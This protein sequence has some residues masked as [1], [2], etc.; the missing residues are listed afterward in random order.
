MDFNEQP[1]S[2]QTPASFWDSFL[3]FLRQYSVIGLAI[4]V[5]IGTA[6]NEL[7]QSLVKG[8]MTPLIGLLVPQQKFQALTFSV[9]AVE[10]RVGDVVS[11]LLHFVI[12]ALLI[13]VVVKKLL[14]RDE[15]LKK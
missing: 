6:V 8:V 2:R 13:Y 1:A 7:V 3:A 14:R 15:L 4:G 10:F 5:V 12:V 11:S 9:R